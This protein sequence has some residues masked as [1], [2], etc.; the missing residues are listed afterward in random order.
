MVPCEVLEKIED[1]GEEGRESGRLK[2]RVKVE[3][4]EVER[5]L[6]STTV[7]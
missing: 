7:D 1:V 6:F 3:L 5:S 4:E 2:D